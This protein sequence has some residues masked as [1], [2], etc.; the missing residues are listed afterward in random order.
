MYMST[1]FGALKQVH[2]DFFQDAKLSNVLMDIFSMNLGKF[3]VKH[4]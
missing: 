4:V 3:F 2:I 1:Q